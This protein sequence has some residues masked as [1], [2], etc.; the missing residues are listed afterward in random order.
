SSS[1]RFRFRSSASPG[2]GRQRRRGR[3]RW[4]RGTAARCR[5]RGPGSRTGS[6]CREKSRGAWVKFRVGTEGGFSFSVPQ[7]KTATMTAPPLI[8]NVRPLDFVRPA[9]VAEL[10]D[11]VRKAAADGFGLFPIGGRTEL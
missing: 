3:R 2:R 11:L 8:D 5:R 10:G 9:S 4:G 6:G 1:G 7:R